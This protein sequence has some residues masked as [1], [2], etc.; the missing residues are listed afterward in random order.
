[1]NKNTLV[2]WVI[3]VSFFGP[4]LAAPPVFTVRQ[5]PNQTSVSR[6]VA[7]VRGINEVGQVVGA[8]LLTSGTGP[9]RAFIW[10]PV[11]GYRGLGTTNRDDPTTY[12]IA[13]GLNDKG[14]V[15]GET[16]NADIG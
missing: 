3:S 12:S 10:D 7:I 16:G 13:W 4:A 14:V 8:S 15:V 9:Y 6:W 1:M 5:V 2:I 11:T